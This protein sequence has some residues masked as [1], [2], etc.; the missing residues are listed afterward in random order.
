M[1]SHEIWLSFWCVSSQQNV[2][3]VVVI[4]EALS[5]FVK[6]PSTF[7]ALQSVYLLFETPSCQVGN[8]TILGSPCLRKASTWEDTDRCCSQQ[9]WLSI[10]P[11]LWPFCW[12]QS[13]ASESPQAFQMFQLRS[14]SGSRD[15]SRQLCP[16]WIPDALYHQQDKGG[17]RLQ[18]LQVTRTVL[19]LLTQLFKTSSTILLEKMCPQS[20]RPSHYL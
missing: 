18:S 7:G 20:S 1:D 3:E 9:S 15:K 4:S 16:F 10:L 6:C 19:T 11:D 13:P 5:Y 2:V 8:Q 14:T 12:F 17:L